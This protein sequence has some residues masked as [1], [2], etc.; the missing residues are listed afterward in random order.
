MDA[1]MTS[2]EQLAQDNMKLAYWMASRFASQYRVDPEEAERQALAALTAAANAYDPNRGTKF[3]SVA[4]PYIRNALRRLVKPIQGQKLGRVDLD[5]PFGDDEGGDDTAHDVVAG[6]GPDVSVEREEVFDKVQQ[7]LASLP[8]EERELLSRWIAGETYRD[9][10]DDAGVSFVQVGNIIRK[11]LVKLKSQLAGKGITGMDALA[12]EAL[13]KKLMGRMV[14]EGRLNL[15]PKRPV[16]GMPT[17]SEM[18]KSRIARIKRRRKL[19]SLTG[20]TKEPR[21]YNESS[22][23]VR[24]IL[25]SAD[26]E[27]IYGILQNFSLED[28]FGYQKLGGLERLAQKYAGGRMSDE[29]FVMQVKSVIQRASA[30]EYSLGYMQGRGAA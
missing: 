11:A 17:A 13:V 16:T 9:I 30:A 24:E 28:D 1:T 5:S 25:Q 10:A 27:E 4:G 23:H 8:P 6:T 21:V 20:D 14:V 26:A 19:Q 15:G 3:S 2:P 18:E 12:T 7:E 29:D 22:G